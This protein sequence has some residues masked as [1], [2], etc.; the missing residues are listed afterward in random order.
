MLD[1]P[2]SATPHTLTGWLSRQGRFYEREEAA[3]YDSC[4][5]RP[6][7]ECGAPAEKMYIR[8]VPC[9]AAADRARFLALPTAPWTDDNPVFI[10]DSDECF[11]DEGELEDWCADHE[12]AVT[13]LML[14]HGKSQRP[15]QFDAA[16]LL[17]DYLGED[18]DV[19][20]AVIDA[21]E[22]FNA[23]IRT[24]LTTMW[25]P[26]KTAVDMSGYVAPP[27]CPRCGSTEF[28]LDC[29][30]TVTQELQEIIDFCQAGE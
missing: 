27:T 26:S 13:D 28:G 15:P 11:W 9:R 4:T 5:H 29:P 21:M 7:Q 12:V 1:S 10:Y 3:R 22:A 24:H 2:E 16:D 30:C 8:C 25:Y 19:P 18:Y 23:A 6:C 20:R 14:V 17:N